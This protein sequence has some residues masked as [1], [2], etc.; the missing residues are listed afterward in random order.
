PRHE[1]NKEV[2]SR[3]EFTALY[4]ITFAQYLSFGYFL[5]FQ[6][7]GLQVDAGIL[8]GPAEFHQVISL[9]AVVKRNEFFFVGSF[10][11]NHDFGCIHEVDYSVSFGY[12]QRS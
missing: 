12:H 8:V 6:Y 4:S 5:T 2:S 1:G 7:H 9:D 10:V 11:A 3:S